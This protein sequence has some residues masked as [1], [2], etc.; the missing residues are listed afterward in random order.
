MFRYDSK[1]QTE[2]PWDADGTIRQ[3]RD[4]S[5]A[6]R[7]HTMMSSVDEGGPAV[8]PRGR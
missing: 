2:S 3:A 4:L 5:D 7:T 8:T 1:P 6:R